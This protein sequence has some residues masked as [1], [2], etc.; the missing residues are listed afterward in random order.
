LVAFELS[1]AGDPKHHGWVNHEPSPR[2]S[3]L[4][5]VVAIAQTVSHG[6]VTITLFS[7]ESYAEGFAVHG[8]YRLEEGHPVLDDIRRRWEEVRRSDAEA[9]RGAPSAMDDDARSEANLRILSG[10]PIAR[11]FPT[12][13]DDRGNRYRSGLFDGRGRGEEAAF[14]YAFTPPLDP[15][16]RGLQIEFPALHWL[17]R[18]PDEERRVDGETEQGPWTFSIPLPAEA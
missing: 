10:Q 3:E 12:A 17:V 18:E 5:G 4:L 6:N 15:T 2:L 16:A 7:L 9:A 11:L 8:R 1:P 14:S 13:T